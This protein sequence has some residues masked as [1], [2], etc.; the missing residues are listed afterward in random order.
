MVQGSSFGSVSLLRSLFVGD[1]ND[2]LLVVAEDMEN[3]MKYATMNLMILLSPC[4]FIA[5][6]GWFKLGH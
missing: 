6:V 5:G 1:F 3:V 4:A 2:V